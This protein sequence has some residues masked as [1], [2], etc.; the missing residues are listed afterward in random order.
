MSNQAPFDCVSC[1]TVPPPRGM[2]HPRGRCNPGSCTCIAPW[3]AGRNSPSPGRTGPQSISRSTD[4]VSSLTHSTSGKDMLRSAGWAGGGPSH[5]LLNHLREDNGPVRQYGLSNTVSCAT[6]P[7]PKVTWTD[8]SHG[9]S[10]LLNTSD[11]SG[12]K[13]G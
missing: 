8:R 13:K 6:S 2:T 5:T 4:P 7:S 11:A 9:R 3:K 1:I 10:R 12:E